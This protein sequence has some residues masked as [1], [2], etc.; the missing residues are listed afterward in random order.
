V[1]RTSWSPQLIWGSSM[2]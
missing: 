2:I 1:T